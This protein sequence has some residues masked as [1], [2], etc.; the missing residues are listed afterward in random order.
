MRVLPLSFLLVALGCGTPLETPTEGPP[1]P[2]PDV[3]VVTVTAGPI[4][5]EDVLPGRVV[6][7]R[8]AEVRPLVSGIVRARL[9]TEGETVTAGQPLYRIDTTVF[10]AEV[11]GAA[12]TAARQRAA[13]ST[14]AREAARARDLVGNGAISGQ[15]A[16]NAESALALAQADLAVSETMLQRSRI[17]L[18]YAT[19]TAPISGRI[20]ISR[21]SEG[22]LVGTA[23]PM[24]MVTIQQVDEVYV[25]IQQPAARYEEVRASLARGDIEGGEALPVTLL[26]LRGEP[27]EAQGRLLFTDITV[28]PT[29]SQLTLRVLV[30]NADM[31]LLP[32]MFVRARIPFGRDPSAITV[33]QQAIQH[34]PSLGEN[35][36]VVDTGDVVAV[37]AVVTGRVVDGQQIVREGLVTGD[38]V[39]VEGHD[40]LAAG[41]P[42]HPDPWTPPSAHPEPS[43][44]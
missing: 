14:A 6:P 27:Y 20:G 41:M 31:R 9:F 8:V 18:R 35:V 4:V 44:P 26:S 12:A 21:V 34:D 3:S 39:I 24:S 28:D 2:P 33:P 19:V 30:P 37:R 5:V 36:L 7:L 22:S 15:S 17:S 1:P 40:R 43:A 23:D 38:R 11:A 13:L 29:T 10:R 25:D 16:D 32:G 42:V